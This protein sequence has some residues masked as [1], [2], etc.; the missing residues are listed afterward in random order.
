MHRLCILMLLLALIPSTLYALGPDEVL[1]VYN[2]NPFTPSDNTDFDSES[3]TVAQHYATARGIPAGNL[4][5]LQYAPYSELISGSVYREFIATPISDYLSS[6]PDIKC[7]VT[8]Y[9]VPS[10]IS[11]QTDY[12]MFVDS[13][14]TLLGN[15]GVPEA[16]HWALCLQ[17]PYCGKNV[18]FA[19]FRDS[20]ENAIQT[21]VNGEPVTWK[22][23]YLVSRLD[24]FSEPT[25]EVTVSIGGTATTV[26]I[27]RD[28]K[29]AEA[30]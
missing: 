22:L 5:G 1:V 3:M 26:A 30:R 23:N 15:P 17:N 10:I 18:D 6:H 28:V 27:P 2:A 19:K 29:H 4:L 25:E 11:Y 13:A 24:G 8:C 16:Q 12:N 7:I 9:G 20:S 21:T 14:L